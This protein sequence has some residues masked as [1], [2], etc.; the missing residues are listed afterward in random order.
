MAMLVDRTSVLIGYSLDDPDTRQLL[1]L[2]KRRLGRLA[3]PLWTIQVAAPA[4]VVSRFERRGVKVINLPARRGK[5]VGDQLEQLFDELG[6]YWRDRLPGTAVSTDDR[7]TA[8]LVLSD[9]RS[10]ICFFAIPASIVGWYRD[11]AFPLVE[12]RGMIPVTARDVLSPPGTTPTK[13]D[14]LIDRAA[15]VIIE[16]GSSW[17]DYEASVALARKEANQVLLIA[18]GDRPLSSTLTNYRVIRRPADFEEGAAAFVSAFSQWIS[19]YESPAELTSF[20]PERLLKLKEYDAA[21]ISATASLEISLTRA[22]LNDDPR[23]SRSPSLRML[24]QQARAQGLFRD[25][26]EYLRIERAVSLRNEALHR[27]RRVTTSEAR[28]GVGAIRSFVD[29][30][31]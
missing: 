31:R 13:V 4:H 27:G 24:L 9:E 21:L 25:E 22:L 7:V 20:E 6:Q 14:A 29:R 15:V 2:V 8:D 28:Q 17:S 5:G 12:N 26:S 16:L 19:A 18:D 3:R 11:V 23:S 10:R 1:G 30:L